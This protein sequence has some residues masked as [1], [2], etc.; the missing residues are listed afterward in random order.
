MDKVHR[1]YKVFTET[2]LANL[3]DGDEIVVTTHSTYPSGSKLLKFS[4]KRDG[5]TLGLYVVEGELTKQHGAV[6]G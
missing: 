6:G 3:D 4:R 1:V 5:L 2:C